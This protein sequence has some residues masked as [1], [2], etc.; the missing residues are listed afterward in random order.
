MPPSPAR[1]RSRAATKA[2]PRPGT[3]GG[4]ALRLERLVPSGRSL[5]VGFALVGVAA[6]L[7]LVARQ[8]SLVAVRSV[9]VTGAPAA[10][11]ARIEQALQPLVGV[12][13]VRIG[14]GSV[15]ER[16]V[17]IPEVETVSIDRAFPHRLTVAITT[18]RRVAVL[19]QGKET[20]VVSERGRVLATAR[21]TD[22]PALPRIW[23]PAAADLSVGATI[24]DQRTV[25]AVSAATAVYRD[26]VGGLRV[27][28]IAVGDNELTYGLRNGIEVRLG[29]LGLLPLKLA[30]ARRILAAGG[31][32]RYVDVSVPERPVAGTNSQVEG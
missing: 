11:Q 12:S 10:V 8:T 4:S 3:S 6:A 24:G 17:S 15:S 27:R 20:F 26:G 13:L 30:I 5:L 19:R 21:R 14:A 9:E 25:A 18:A 7:Y 22:Y 32:E 1:T 31:V 23:L 28:T 2:A 16:L 29:N